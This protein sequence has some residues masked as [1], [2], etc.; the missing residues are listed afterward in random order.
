MI[1][2]LFYV[3]AF[4][5]SYISLYSQYLREYGRGEKLYTNC[6]VKNISTTAGTFEC[7]YLQKKSCFF[8]SKDVPRKEL[9]TGILLYR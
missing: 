6:V 5:L 2:A 8:C 9:V 4:F 1:Q 3:S 7:T